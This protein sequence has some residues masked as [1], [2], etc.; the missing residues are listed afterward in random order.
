MSKKTIKELAEEIGVSKT[1]I[2]KKVTETQKKKWFVK[3]GNQ[4]V[5]SEKGQEAIKSMFDPVENNQSQTQ[6]KTSWRNNLNQFSNSDFYQK[7]L[8]AKD[9]QIDMLQTL[10][11]DQQNLLD[12]QQRLTLQTNKQME[13]LQLESTKN[14]EDNTSQKDSYVPNAETEKETEPAQTKEAFFSRLFNKK[15]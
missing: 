10:L 2:S 3:I 8:L 12:Q 15:K 9:N 1:A 14:T 7:Q 11:K 6:T 4:F 13:Q 5:I